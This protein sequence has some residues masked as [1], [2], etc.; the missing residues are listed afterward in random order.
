M[1]EVV[2][3]GGGGDRV[4][5]RAAAAASRCSGGHKG[6]AMPRA[7]FVSFSCGS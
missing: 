1:R 7:S 5:G 2:K 3:A 4:E 6:E